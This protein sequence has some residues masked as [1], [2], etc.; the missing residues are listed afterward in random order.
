[1]PKYNTLEEYIDTFNKDA[2]ECYH[3]IL[4]IIDEI[5]LD[6]KKRLFAGQLAFY[7]EENLQRTFHS[8]PVIVMAFFKDHVNIFATANI[9]FKNQLH[10]YTFTEKGTMQ[11]QYGKPLHTEILAQLFIESLNIEN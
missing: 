7:I 10:D 6:I 3:S 11:I 9:K 5:D 8:S 4:S 1:M 2:L